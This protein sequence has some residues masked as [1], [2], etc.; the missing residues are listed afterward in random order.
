[1]PPIDPDARATQR[2]DIL[3]RVAQGESLGSVGIS[4]GTY[5]RWRREYAAK[6][7]AGLKTKWTNCGR[8]PLAKL[9]DIEEAVVQK[10]YVTTGSVTLALRS[11]AHSPTCSQVT[12][13]AILKRRRSKHTI[14]RTLRCQV[15]DV[16]PAVH[17]YHC[18]A[19]AAARMFINPRTLAYLDPLGKERKLQA[20]DLSERDDMSNNFIGWIDWPFGGDPC[21]DRYG[22][23]V[24]RG[25]NLLQLDVASLFFQSFCFLVRLRDSYRAD[26][27]W[28]WVGQSYRDIFK[29]AIG[30]RW[31]RGIWKANQL[32]GTPIAPGHTAQETRLGGLQAL[33]LQVIESQ[34]PTT[35]II[36]NRFRYFQRVC[37]TIPGQIGASRGVMERESKLW[38]ECR[39]GRRD[40]RDHFLSFEQ[41]SDEIENK[42][43]FVNA[44]QVEGTLYHGIPAEIYRAGLAQRAERGDAPQRLTAEETYLFSRDLRKATASKAHAMVRY[45]NPDGRRKAWWFH[46]PELFREEGQQLAVYFDLQNAGLGATVVPVRARKPSEEKVPTYACELVEGMPQFAL[47]LDL[48][49]GRGAQAMVDGLERRKAFDQAVR[50]EYRALGF[51]GRRLARSAAVRDGA[52][53][54]VTVEQ[55]NSINDKNAARGGKAG[56]EDPTPEKFRSSRSTTPLSKDADYMRRLEE[57]FLESNPGVEIT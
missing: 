10:L 9:D 46:H 16:S 53:R 1:M 37:A 34:S 21:S 55:R 57:Q 14:T 13:D 50:A 31:E 25:Q 48:D 47:G 29:P 3:I 18:G 41:L 43:H 42:L 52:G 54:S 5:S 7:K 12:A 44:E 40:P 38:T 20:G 23:R 30:E 27:I 56:D 32:R 6:G 33:G 15:K 24:F 28:Q 35:K 36:E 39:E 11:L 49:G 2:E 8:K 4:A 17:A 51:T 22:V 19:R 45:V 26:D